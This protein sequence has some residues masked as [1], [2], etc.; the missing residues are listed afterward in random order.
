[1]D[2]LILLLW[3]SHFYYPIKSPVISYIF[4]KNA[5]K[6]LELM[7]EMTLKVRKVVLE[8][9]GFSSN[10]FFGNLLYTYSNCDSIP[11]NSTDALYG[12]IFIKHQ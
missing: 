9:L 6:A 10:Y 1:M 3:K 12:L 5:G 7:K 8:S 2:H 11:I 4:L